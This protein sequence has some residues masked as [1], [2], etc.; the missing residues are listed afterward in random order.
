MPVEKQM[1]MSGK[2]CRVAIQ[3]VCVFIQRLSTSVL[4]SAHPRLPDVVS[5]ASSVVEASRWRVR[6]RCQCSDPCSGAAKALGK[7]FS[8]TSTER[9]VQISSQK[10]AMKIC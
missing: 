10:A 5:H 1:Q 2:V 7:D 4:N 8:V 9:A 6:L 3:I